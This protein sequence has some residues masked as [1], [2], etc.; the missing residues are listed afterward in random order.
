MTDE[1]IARSQTPSAPEFDPFAVHVPDDPYPMFKHLRDVSPVY[2]NDRR[3]FWA[4]SRYDDVQRA[5]R[6]WEVFT[7]RYGVE[8]DR[9]GKLLRVSS[10]IGEDPPR[11][12]ELRNVVRK[13]FAPKEIRA[14]SGRV[15]QIAA[16]LLADAAVGGSADLASD[17]AWPLG[18]SVVCEL[19]GLPA[20]DRHQMQLWL[21]QMLWRNPGDTEVP[22]LARDSANTVRGYFSDVISARRAPVDGQDLLST[23]MCAELAGRLS[24][25]EVLDLC[26]LLFVAATDTVASVVANALI[27]LGTHEDQRTLLLDEPGMI[28]AA[29]EE[30][31]RYEAPVQFLARQTTVPVSIHGVDIPAGEWVL[32]LHAAANRDERRFRDPETFDIRREHARHLGFGDGI[33]FCIGAPLARLQAESAIAVVLRTMPAYELAAPPERYP[34]YNVRGVSRLPVT[35]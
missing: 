18:V 34:G 20:A 15:N 13:H 35:W 7:N 22:A 8:Q 4:L 3:N 29:I 16:G 33:H 26:G 12:D 1:T 28:P 23:L 2:R 31:V 10:F 19:L 6:D 25:D 32:L 30:V 24:M 21:D 5:S 17:F 27:L 9:W 11:H 14:L